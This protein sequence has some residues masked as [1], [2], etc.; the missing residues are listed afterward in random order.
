VVPVGGG[1]DNSNNINNNNN[2][3]SCAA[4][5]LSMGPRKVWSSRLLVCLIMLFDNVLCCADLEERVSN[6]VFY[7]QSAITLEKRKA[8]ET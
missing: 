8:K 5:Y 1:A 4:Q 6:L 2:K 3:S 7:A